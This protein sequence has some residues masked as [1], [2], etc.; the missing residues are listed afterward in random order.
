MSVKVCD[1]ICGAG[2]TQ[3]CITM[4]N[5]SGNKKFMF[6]TPY[7][8]EVERIKRS[9]AEKNFVSPE[10]TGANHFS[11]LNDIVRLIREGK[12]IATTHALFSNYTDSVK[13]LIQKQKYILILD[14]E[15]NLF[16]PVAIDGGD[17]DFL[18]RNNIAKVENEKVSWVDKHYKGV[19]FNDIVRLAQSRN[20][21]DYDGSFYFWTL[22]MDVFN[23][24]TDVYILTY[25]FEYQPIGHYF[26]AN[27]IKYELIGTTKENGA[28]RFCSM[29]EMDRKLDLRD[30]IHICDNPSFNRVGDA[31]FSLS[32]GWYDRAAEDPDNEELQELKA[33][34]R[35]FLRKTKNG[36]TDKMWTCLNRHRSLLSGKGYSA[37]FLTYNKRATN[38][39]ANKH[40]LAFCLNVYMMPWIQNYLSRI[41]AT[42]VSQGMYAL[43]VLIQ[44]L[45]RSAIRK[46]EEVWLYLPSKRMR[47]L[48][49]GWLNNLAE[50]N[51]LLE[52][53]YKNE[54][55]KIQKESRAIQGLQETLHQMCLQHKKDKR[56]KNN[57]KV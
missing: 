16:Q 37:G 56:R 35:K 11:K 51:D 29:P 26:I 9:C 19:V 25:M 43:S 52:V 41:G 50:G 44:W 15:I 12:N 6:V 18:V 45:F 17:V 48:L 24:F 57:E 28:Y 4:I 46:G 31:A 23:C 27:Q 30:K 32:A 21:V 38:D 14:E 34:I 54:V 47:L 5:N 49:K 55:A 40:Y 22:P 10:Q 2:K 53:T 20:M 13:E 33:D 1:A 7:L 3:S 36:N 8:D 42:K 39:F